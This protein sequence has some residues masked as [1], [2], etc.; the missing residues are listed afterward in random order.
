MWIKG[1]VV[2]VML[3]I[4]YSLG[5]AIISLMKDNNNKDRMV[6]ALIWRVGISMALFLGLFIAYYYG[7]IQPHALGSD[8]TTAW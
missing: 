4:V 3:G 1:I 2:I 7:L 5:S 8:T 6:K